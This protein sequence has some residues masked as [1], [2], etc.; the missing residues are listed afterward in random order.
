VGNDFIHRHVEIRRAGL[1]YKARVL[2]C[3]CGLVLLAG[4]VIAQEPTPT[5]T[6]APTPTDSE[7]FQAMIDAQNQGNLILLF[8]CGAFLVFVAVNNLRP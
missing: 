5:P 6:P 2:A 7:Q 8:A 1:I 3:I 4:P